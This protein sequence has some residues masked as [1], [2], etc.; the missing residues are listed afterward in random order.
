MAQ[1]FD[2]MVQNFDDNMAQIFDNIAQ[3]LEPI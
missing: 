1:I 3:N 2:N